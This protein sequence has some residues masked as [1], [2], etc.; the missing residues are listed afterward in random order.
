LACASPL[1]V[2]DVGRYALFV[3][4]TSRSIRARARI[5]HGWSLGFYIAGIAALGCG[6]IAGAIVAAATAS[7]AGLTVAAI[8]AGTGVATGA[9][10]LWESRRFKRRAENLER[11]VSEQRLHALARRRGGEL[12]VVDVA[13]ELRVTN[14]EAEELLDHTVDEV[15]VSMR[16][17][18]EGS[19]R[20][21]FAELDED[22]SPR[23][24]IEL[25]E[26]EPAA[27]ESAT[28][29]TTDSRV[30]NRNH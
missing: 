4:P 6:I 8:V 7:G 10:G 27:V 24:R 26:E 25:G 17:T 15:R 30:K 28:S 14:A 18:D 1:G 21:V 12:R 5:A 20:Y 16:V 23:V 3:T 2:I 29:T 11:A 9:L 22:S 19:I 13:R